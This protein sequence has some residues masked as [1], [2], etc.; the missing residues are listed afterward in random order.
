MSSYRQ[1]K[2]PDGHVVRVK[3]GFSWQAFFVGS[4]RAMA[5]RTWP[6]VLTALGY[7]AFLRTGPPFHQSPRLLA[8]TAL[9]LLFYFA[10]MVF[11]GLFGNRWLVSSLLRR[12]FRQVV[13]DPH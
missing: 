4:W 2:S 5:R 8:L 1:F 11:C 10:Y 7:L 9:V 6:L 3:V 13:D 12:G